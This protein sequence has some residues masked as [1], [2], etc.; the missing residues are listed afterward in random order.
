MRYSFNTFNH[1]TY[2]G[3]PPTLPRQIEA[4]ASAGYDHVGLDILSVLAHERDGLS[5]RDLAAR[6]EH[7]GLPC[8]ELV[9]L[10]IS[11][12]KASTLR[13]LEQI[14]RVARVLRPAQVLCVVTGEIDDDVVAN[15]A[16]CVRSLAEEHIGLSLEFL[17]TRHV[18]SIP[19][20]LRLLDRVA[21]PGLRLVVESWHFFRGPSTWADLAALPLDRVGFVQ[22]ADAPAPMSD[23]A[24]HE[25]MHR[26]V[27]PGRGV[28]DLDRFCAT[29]VA[30]GYDGV[31]SV[32]LLSES[33][34]TADL[35][36]FADAT[37]AS[38]RS[39]WESATTRFG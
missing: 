20:A 11:A 21:H 13:G 6:L 23:D 4:A 36:E 30:K 9:S 16:T 29:L 12:N 37:L 8:H 1:S 19:E 35:H 7:H 33:W 38:S 24:H 15:T 2:Y 31:V 14:L 27:L 10:S 18:D 22:F 32:E 26:R 39:V 3:L 25:S 5:P 28:L 17:P 34:R